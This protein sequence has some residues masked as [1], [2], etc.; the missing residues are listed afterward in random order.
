LKILELQINEVVYLYKGKDNEYENKSEKITLVT[1]FLKENEILGEEITD[2]ESNVPLLD[3]SQ[4]LKK[5]DIV[6]KEI[7]KEIKELNNKL[8]NLQEI[9]YSI[10]DELDVQ[11][12]I[13]NNIQDKELKE[14]DTLLTLKKNTDYANEQTN[15]TTRLVV[16]TCVI[17]GLLILFN[18]LF[19]FI[20]ASFIK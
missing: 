6:K 13:L 11:E 2:L 3:I 5:V 4:S 12:K 20:A 14:T 9:S 17:I 7:D 10:T 19:I 18:C 16:I 1:D 15:T 8:S